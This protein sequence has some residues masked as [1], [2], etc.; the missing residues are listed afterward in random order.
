MARTFRLEVLT[1]E[2]VL[3]RDR[4]VEFVL[5]PARDGYYGILAGHAPMVGLLKPGVLQY[6]E[7]GKDKKAVAVLGGFFEVE[8]ERTLVM[9]DEAEFPEEIDVAAAMAERERARA[10]LEGG[11]NQEEVL[12]ARRAYEKAMARLRTVGQ[13]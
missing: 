3:V 6:R 12:R 11:G 4:E 9:A 10:V 5:L 2:R 13:S 1:S 8:P 7:P